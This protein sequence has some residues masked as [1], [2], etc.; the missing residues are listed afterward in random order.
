MQMFSRVL[1]RLRVLFESPAFLSP[2]Q[3][4][5]AAFVSPGSACH[6][7]GDSGPQLKNREDISVS[8]FFFFLNL[9]KGPSEPRNVK[10]N[11][12]SKCC[13]FYRPLF[14]CLFHALLPAKNICSLESISRKSYLSPFI[15][16]KL[17][18][19]FPVTCWKEEPLPRLKVIR[20]I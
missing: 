4:A 16:V 19:A 8:C 13:G 5:A 10:L 14:L 17:I 11:F 2:G 6:L 7:G 20:P 1:L 3:G 18:L 12:N 9:L 15:Q